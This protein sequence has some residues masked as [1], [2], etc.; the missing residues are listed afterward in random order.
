MGQAQSVAGGLGEQRRLFDRIGTRLE[1]VGTRFPLVNSLLGAIRRKRSKARPPPRPQLCSPGA[2]CLVC[3]CADCL[4]L[5]LLRRLCWQQFPAR[6]GLRVS[7]RRAQRLHKEVTNACC[8][9][10]RTG[11][12]GDLR[13]SGRL[14]TAHLLLLAV[15]VGPRGP[16]AVGYPFANALYPLL[17]RA[18]LLLWS[19]VSAR[20]QALRLC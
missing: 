12:A 11:H 10:A 4:P 15:Q 6:R 19:V 7:R 9:A 8:L 13:G 17:T 20:T 3:A 16:G 18:V 2:Q 1:D 14:Y 5:K